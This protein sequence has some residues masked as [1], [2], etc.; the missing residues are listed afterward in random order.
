MVTMQEQQARAAQFAR[1]SDE[2]IKQAYPFGVLSDYDIAR[3]REGQS[4]R[5][6][7]KTIFEVAQATPNIDKNEAV[8]AMR[9]NVQ[10]PQG[11]RFDTLNTVRSNYEKLSSEGKLNEY[12]KGVVFSQSAGVKLKGKSFGEFILPVGA[13]LQKTPQQASAASKPLQSQPLQSRPL[14]NVFATSRPATPAR[15]A[16]SAT[17]ARQ[18][19][20]SASNIPLG[21]RAL[22]WLTAPGTTLSNNPLL[23]S[24]TSRPSMGFSK[25]RLNSMM[26]TSS[27][28]FDNNAFRKMLWGRK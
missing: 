24:S 23:G 28:G 19:I 17:V 26:F 3:I 7:Q 20:Q 18:S 15:P 12:S 11:V 21:Q 14:D 16:T 5:I 27:K 13:P 22:T 4:W 9:G 1:M 10:N 2:E 25:A 8:M 6:P